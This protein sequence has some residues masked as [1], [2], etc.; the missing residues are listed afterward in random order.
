MVQIILSKLLQLQDRGEIERMAA[1]L[2]PEEAKALIQHIAEF[3]KQFEEKIEPLL[4]GFPDSLLPILK[5]FAK[6]TI[7]QHKAA[8][9]IGKI[10]K[11]LMENQVKLETLAER[12]ANFPLSPISP[13]ALSVL[14]I[15]IQEVFEENAAQ[16]ELLNSLIEIAWLAE[17]SDLVAEISMLKSTLIH[18]S[19][20]LG[21]LPALL[22]KRLEEV[23][24]TL[25]DASNLEALRCLGFTYPEDFAPLKIEPGNIEKEL[26][27][28]GLST[29][30]DFKNNQIY[31]K[32]MLISYLD[33]VH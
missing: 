32:E 24:G 23:L 3:P 31:T 6:N 25:D 10:K 19:Y 5:P 11:N 22:L 7:V 14:Q 15:D 18:L 2:P 12:T 21:L 20:H 28:R 27:K 8:A 13:D 16:I 9:L 26:A 33:K 1:E 4:A 17:R 29:V 30:K